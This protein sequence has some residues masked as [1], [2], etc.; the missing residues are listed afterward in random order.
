MYYIAGVLLLFSMAMVLIHM[1]I[2]YRVLKSLSHCPQPPYPDE[3]CP[4][5]MVVMCLRGSDPF[6]EATLRSIFAQDYPHYVVKLIVDSVH[7]TAW[8]IVHRIKEELHA[9]HVTIQPHLKRRAGCSL[10]CGSQIEALETIDPS[11]E[12]LAFLDADTVPHAT[13]LRELAAALNQPGVGAATGGRWYAPEAAT[14][15]AVMRYLWNVAAQALMTELHIAWGGTLAF[16]R[17]VFDQ[18]KLADRWSKAICEDTMT[19]DALREMNLKVQ[20]VPTLMMVNR[21]DISV[22]S[23][24][25]WVTRQLLNMRLYHSNWWFVLLHGLSVFVVVEGSLIFSLVAALRGYG[26]EALLAIGA[27]VLFQSTL[28]LLLFLLE[29]AVLNLSRPRRRLWGAWWVWALIP[30]WMLFV[31]TMNL[32]CVLRAQFTRRIEWRGV[33]YEVLS[34]FHIRIV[35]ETEVIVSATQSI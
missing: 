15:G 9:S 33:T 25:R 2:A 29:R 19:Q 12:M 17:E 18:L 30:V 28:C 34:P 3:K 32:W 31:Q 8:G 24:R 5:A 16:R 4:K 26:N 21:E 23:F 6:L 35:E 7:D 11:I 20:F 14:P 27:A 13:W 22:N 10:K 1:V